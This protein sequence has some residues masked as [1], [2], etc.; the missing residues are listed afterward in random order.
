MTTATQN[1]PPQ[2]N[3]PPLNPYQQ[4]GNMPPDP[5]LQP[6]PNQQASDPN[7][8]REELAGRTFKAYEEME[9]AID[10]A[11]G[12]L[13]TDLADYKA[14]AKQRTADEG[15]QAQA[16]FES[17]E[18]DTGVP[19]AD[20]DAARHQWAWLHDKFTSYDDCHDG[21]GAQGRNAHRARSG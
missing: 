1:L 16:Y 10:E 14:A 17:I 15:L 8:A 11:Y 6:A 2:G 3:M 12:R 9:G 5:N 19:Q 4:A 18:H 21:H 7:E 20:K 13:D